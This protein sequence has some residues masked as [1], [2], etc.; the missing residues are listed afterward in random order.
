M[1]KVLVSAAAAALLVGA[2]GAGAANAASDAAQTVKGHIYTL[3]GK[4]VSDA[5]VQLRSIDAQ[6]RA[7]TL[8]VHTSSTGRYSFPVVEPGVYALTASDPDGDYAPSEHAT[9]V[10]VTTKDIRANKRLHQA[11]HLSGTLKDSDG[12]PLGNV[13]VHLVSA[14]SASHDPGSTLIETD[15]DGTYRLDGLSAGSYLVYFDADG[16]QGEWYSNAPQWE[17][18]KAV[19]LHYGKKTTHV[20]ATLASDPPQAQGNG[21]R[22]Q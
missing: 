19:S 4:P 12:D 16:Y 7:T 18:A 8:R 6:G 17:Q 20:S 10:T 14:T 3:S 21:G 9:R 22:N 11:A 15:A 13:E 2:G 5:L 1:K